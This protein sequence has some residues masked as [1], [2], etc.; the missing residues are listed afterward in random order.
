MTVDYKDTAVSKVRN[1]LWD[2]LVANELL[3]PQDYLA[4]GFTGLLVP[5]IPAQQ[6]PEFNNLIS[7]KT[8]IVYDF[9]IAGYGEEFW[10]CEENVLFSI[11]STSY[12]QVVELTNFMVDLFRRMDESA[13]D[14]NFA[15]LS[16]DVFKFFYI[17]INSASS[18]TP[19]TEEGGNYMG[20][21]D[22]TYKYSRHLDGNKRFV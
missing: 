13:K 1:F 19:M 4:D 8:Y 5:V 22:I 18:P 14:V 6:V 3:D 15:L 16:T 10:M 9:D 12:Q 21:V 11:F 17:T 20:Q 2:Q 7:G